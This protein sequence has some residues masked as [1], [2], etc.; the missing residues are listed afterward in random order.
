VARPPT[1]ASP[2][3]LFRFFKD[4]P[5][6]IIHDLCDTLD[7]PGDN[8]HSGTRPTTPGRWSAL[9]QTI[10]E[11]SVVVAVATGWSWEY[12]DSRAV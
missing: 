5:L 11:V 9:V 1:A 3:V 8:R 6:E 12:H 7:L 4:L 10:T 2:F